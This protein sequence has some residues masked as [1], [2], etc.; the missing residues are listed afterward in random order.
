MK[1][2]WCYRYYESRNIYVFVG[3]KQEWEDYISNHGGCYTLVKQ[4]PVIN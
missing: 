2:E 4:I 3:T 1:Y